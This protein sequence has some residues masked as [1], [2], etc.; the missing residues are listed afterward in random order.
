MLKRC[1]AFGCS[2]THWYFWPT[3]ADFIGVNFEKYYNFGNPGTS[4][5]IALQRF[6]E[7]NALLKFTDQDLILIGL[8][9]M[10]RYNWLESR[11]PSFEKK[12]KP[13]W[14]CHGD[15]ENW[16]QNENSNFIRKNLW[17]HQWGIY[18]TWLAIHNIKTILDLIGAKYHFIMAMDNEHFLDS[19][20]FDLTVEESSMAKDI[21]QIVNCQES[22]QN[23]Q[24]PY[25]HILNDSH[26]SIDAHFDYVKKYFSEYVTDKSIFLKNE[27]KRI[28][29][30]E[31]YTD[32]RT[33]NT[34]MHKQSENHGRLIRELCPNY[35]PNVNVY[36]KYV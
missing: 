36:G 10:G 18:D 32:S 5:K 28:F 26:P 27:S 3:W 34:L 2:F 30:Q 7:I 14:F 24:K 31:L 6:I 4:N 20:L 1:F 16:P 19:K 13:V 25:R 21:F 23:F 11:I 8:T 17:R 29:I 15:P 33:D 22:L 9:S 35:A 12:E